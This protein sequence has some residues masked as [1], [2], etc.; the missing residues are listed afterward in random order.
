V[1]S[2]LYGTSAHDVKRAARAVAHSVSLAI[3]AGLVDGWT[4]FVGDCSPAQALTDDDL[5]DIA[6]IVSAAGGALDHVY[7]GENLGSARG[8]NTLAARGNSTLML[9][10]NPDAIVAPDTVTTLCGALVDD[11]GIAEARQVPIEHPKDYDTSTGDTSWASTACALTRRETFEA[12]GGFDSETFFLY[13][14]DVDYSWRVKIAG[15]RVVFV[16]EA[17]V[18]HDKRLGTDGSWLAGSAE[19]YY[20]AEA[21]LLLPLKYSRRDIERHVRRQLMASDDEA[22]ARALAEVDRRVAAKSLASA[23]DADHKVAQFVGP[24]YARHRFP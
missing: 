17:T 7:F 9:I 24:N 14:D 3:G 11:V 20:S 23:I 22:A 13:C 15:L 8:H 19:R 16:P 12:V 5:S 21:A 4:Y 18:F 2:V 6:A 1:Q 10:L